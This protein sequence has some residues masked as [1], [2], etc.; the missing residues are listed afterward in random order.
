M[1]PKLK[2]VPLL[3]ACSLIGSCIFTIPLST[4]INQH[5][6]LGLN[7]KYTI[8]NSKQFDTICAKSYPY[9][10]CVSRLNILYS[11]FTGNWLKLINLI[12]SHY[13]WTN[14]VSSSLPCNTWQSYMRHKDFL[15]S[16][17]LLRPSRSYHPP[18]ILKRAGKKVIFWDFLKFFRFS[19]FVY[20]FWQCLDFWVFFMDF[21]DL[22]LFVCFWNFLGFI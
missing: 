2:E 5:F 18:W 17:V 19:I 4:R 7:K 14:L 20:H 21:L 16:A 22:C 13:I 9:V 8:Q 11:S 12:R 3:S 10:Y 15:R 1:C 6:F